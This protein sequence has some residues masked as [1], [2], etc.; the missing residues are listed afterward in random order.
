MYIKF[1][2][3]LFVLFMVCGRLTCRIHLR[4]RTA[5]SIRQKTVPMPLKSFSVLRSSAWTKPKFPFRFASLLVT[6]VS[7][8]TETYLS[9]TTQ[10]VTSIFLGLSS[11]CSVRLG[12]WIFS[13]FSS[14]SIWLVA[15]TIWLLSHFISNNSGQYNFTKSYTHSLYLTLTIFLRQ[16]LNLCLLLAH[17]TNLWEELLFSKMAEPCSGNSQWSA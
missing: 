1:V 15:M 2:F 13:R 4:L 12:L 3:S 11:Q 10:L 5:H 16:A 14:S 17:N 9:S 8:E 7:Y 6:T